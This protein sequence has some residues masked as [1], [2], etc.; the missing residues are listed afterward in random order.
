MANAFGRKDSIWGGETLTCSMTKPALGV[1][2]GD[3]FRVEKGPVGKLTLIPDPANQG[4]WNQSHNAANP[5]KINP[6][7]V[8]PT[9]FKRAYSMMVTIKQGDQPTQLFLAETDGGSVWISAKA[10]RDKKDEAFHKNDHD[11]AGVER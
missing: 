6:N 4:T 10:V 1:V 8:A 9:S 5:V 7:Q 3:R 11:I 2:D